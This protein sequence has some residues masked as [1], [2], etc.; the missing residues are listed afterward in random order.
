MPPPLF[1]LLVNT[2]VG[3]CTVV[4]SYIYKADLTHGVSTAQGFLFSVVK[5]AREKG[6]ICSFSCLQDI[7]FVRT[8]G[9]FI[10]N[11][12]SN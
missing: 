2:R 3:A 11:L 1:A 10:G 5:S 9:H 8:T 7:S 4:E 6:R 12:L